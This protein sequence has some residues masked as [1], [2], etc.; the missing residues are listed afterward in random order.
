VAR[1]VGRSLT[2]GRATGRLLVVDD[3]PRLATQLARDLRRV[4]FE[5]SIA[6]T[7][8]RAV[9]ALER[10]RP[11]LLIVDPAL[12]GE[13]AERFIASI[14]GRTSAAILVVSGIGRDAAHDALR[15]HG[16]GYLRKP[17]RFDE[18]RRRVERLLATAAET[19]QRD[20]VLLGPDVALDLGRRRVRRGSAWLILTP[21]ETRFLEVLLET[22]GRPLPTDLLLSRVW[23]EVD[24]P[25]PAYVWVA[26]R[27]LRA[28]I[29]QEPGRP[30]YLLSVRGR[31][32]LLHIAGEADATRD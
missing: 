8:D 5:V 25:D 28:K 31:G 30:R 12:R 2:V 32:Y 26:V 17:F 16:D 21:I 29:E 14:A 18:L 4:G 9:D 20:E 13:D 1:V 7:A 10:I 3:D 27:R 24:A 23:P 11:D 19:A 22:P 15:E 6:T